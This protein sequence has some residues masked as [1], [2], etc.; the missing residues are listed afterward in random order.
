MEHVETILNDILAEL[1]A[2][3]TQAQQGP[4]PFLGIDEVATALGLSAKTVRN[5]LS[6]KAFPLRATKIGGRV[7]F[8]AA[9]LE[10]F[11]K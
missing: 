9:D 6:K 4:R 8:R 5:Q 3:R 7:L 11:G 2:L 1:K 10:S